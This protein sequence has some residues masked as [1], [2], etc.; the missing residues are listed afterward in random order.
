MARVDTGERS[1]DLS[2]AEE[3]LSEL[4]CQAKENQESLLNKKI[5]VLGSQPRVGTTFVA[6]LITGCLNRLGVPACYKENPRK[7]WVVGSSFLREGAFTDGEYW[8]GCFR[9]IPDYG[10]FV[11]AGRENEKV[12]DAVSIHDLGVLRPECGLDA[13]SLIILVL[14]ARAWE[15]RISEEQYEA[16]KGRRNCVLV[17]SLQTRDEV[18]ALS[19]ILGKEVYLIPAMES[20]YQ[21]EKRVRKLMLQIKGQIISEKS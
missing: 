18:K 10:P 12:A 8:H 7:R 13:F 2:E 11:E 6:T 19:R 5:A 9:T 14:G 1:P 20:P 4:R 21:P 3:V 15:Q 16:L 17:S